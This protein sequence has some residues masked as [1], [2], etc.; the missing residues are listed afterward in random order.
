M[1]RPVAYLAAALLLACAL[2]AHAAGQSTPTTT[3]APAAPPLHHPPL[4]HSTK[5]APVKH[6]DLKHGA[7]KHA[8]PAAVPV[9]APHHHGAVRHKV[10]A[11][12][13]IAPATHG[14]RTAHTAATHRMA[15][16]ASLAKPAA[17]PKPVPKKPEPPPVPENIGTN[18]GLPLPRYASLKSDDVNM[19][20]GPGERYPVEWIY[21][22]HELPVKIEREFDIWRLVEDMDGTKGWVHQATLTGRRSFVITGTQDRTL[23]AD[24]SDGAA[25]VAILKPGVV[26]RIRACAAGQDWCQVQVQDYRGWLQRSDFWGTDPNEAISP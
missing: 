23:R 17:V 24:A 16:Q 4:H 3:Q 21:K 18:T 19:R 25:A 5:K 1:R 12:A 7:A 14:A 22:R 8:A 10:V 26:G 11:T 9:V 15:R 13:H 2:P 20:K 6:R